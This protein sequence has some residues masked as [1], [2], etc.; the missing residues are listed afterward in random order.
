MLLNNL[1]RDASA[2][3][4]HSL[5]ASDA[6]MSSV[7]CGDGYVIFIINQSIDPT[8]VFAVRLK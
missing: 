2:S 1:K 7:Y 8:N 3:L 6:S 5:R 4:P